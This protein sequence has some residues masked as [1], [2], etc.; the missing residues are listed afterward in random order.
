MSHPKFSA[1]AVHLAVCAALSLWA[2]CAVAQVTAAEE[3]QLAR[4]DVIARIVPERGPGGRLVAA[5]DIPASP[6]AVWKVMLDCVRA[7][8]YVPGLE[9][10]RVLETAA[11][12]RSDVREHHIRWLA[13]LPALTL[14]F[15][16]DYVAEREI[17]VTQVA[18]DLATM[19]GTWRLESR[20]DG[21][22]TRLHYDFRMAP[23]AP[24]PATLVR[25]GLLRDTPKVLRAVRTE[26]ARGAAP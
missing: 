10:C 23:K 19:Q 21:R 13:F 20:D 8:A 7:P 14:R 3:A 26:V 5:I 6:G 1:N 18:G 15:R 2:S 4:G 24:V 12:G 25:A 17:R 22:A 11:D 9:S 16:S